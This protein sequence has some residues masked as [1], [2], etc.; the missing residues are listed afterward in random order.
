MTSSM[1]QLTGTISESIGDLTVFVLIFMIVMLG[2]T[3]V[4]SIP[5]PVLNQRLSALI[6]VRERE[7]RAVSVFVN[8]LDGD[9]SG[10]GIQP[11]LWRANTR[12]LGYI[13]VL[14][15][16]FQGHVTVTFL[17]SLE[18]HCCPLCPWPYC[19]FYLVFCRRDQ[20]RFA[21]LASDAMM[22]SLSALIR[23]C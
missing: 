12:L 5:D 21:A 4:L 13:V 1:N 7:S 9:L 11:A 20:M 14:H 8:F 23:H 2:F 15:G 16:S 6:R 17:P 3:Q 22:F 19:S 10:T 18:S